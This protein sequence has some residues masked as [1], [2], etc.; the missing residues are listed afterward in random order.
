MKRKAPLKRSTKPIRR[1]GR[2][3]FPGR[4]DPRYRAEIREMLCVVFTSA[5][6]LELRLPERDT[7]CGGPEEC[8]HVKTQGSGGYDVGNCVPVCRKHHRE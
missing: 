8:A 5:D 1:R 6:W 3:R 7:R 2:R 4:C